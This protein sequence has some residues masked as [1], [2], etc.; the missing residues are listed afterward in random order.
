[1][2][3][4][5]FMSICSHSVANAIKRSAAIFGQHSCKRRRGT[6][7][8]DQFVF[9]D[10]AAKLAARNQLTPLPQDQLKREDITV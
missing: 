6:V 4:A 7:F 10:K 5:L 3:R 1:M 8:T 2:K 9:F